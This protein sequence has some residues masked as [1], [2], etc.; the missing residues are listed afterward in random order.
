MWS[1]K[2]LSVGVVLS[3]LLLVSPVRSETATA[4]LS[5][6]VVFSM[7]TCT[8]TMP[9]SVQLK[10]LNV[11]TVSHPPV[12]IDIDC[13]DGGNIETGLYAGK[14]SGELSGT[15]KMTMVP[16]SGSV[17]GNPALLW[18]TETAGVPVK[19]DGTGADVADNAFCRGTGVKRSCSLTPVTQVFP[20]T[21]GEEVSATVRFNVMYP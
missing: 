17:T 12:S 14:V 19:L 8:L 11:G 6:P 10:V 20:D 7:P 1:G 13:P 21:V 3:T 5:I 2:W 15:D 18:L 9:G 4:T 16:S